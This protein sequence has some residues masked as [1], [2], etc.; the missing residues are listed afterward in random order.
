MTIVDKETMRGQNQ[1]AIRVVVAGQRGPNVFAD[2]TGLPPMASHQK[3]AAREAHRSSRCGTP[4]NSSRPDSHNIAGLATSKALCNNFVDPGIWLVNQRL[5]NRTLQLAGHARVGTA[6]ARPRSAVCRRHVDATRASRAALL[7]I[8]TSLRRRAMRKPGP[9]C[10]PPA[11]HD[12]EPGEHHSRYPFSAIIRTVGLNP[13]L[14]RGRVWPSACRGRV[15]APAP[16][17]SRRVRYRHRPPTRT[18]T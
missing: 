5:T 9:S 1:E 2:G 18:K 8:P 10:S 3:A 11:A 14:M 13:C 17:A 15:A 16:D 7:A 4:S 6:R 12:P